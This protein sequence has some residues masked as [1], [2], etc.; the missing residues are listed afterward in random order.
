MLASGGLQTW[1]PRY[2]VSYGKTDE[3]KTLRQYIHN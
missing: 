2:G 1:Q 3:D